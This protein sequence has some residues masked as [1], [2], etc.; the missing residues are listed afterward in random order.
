[1][2]C[3]EYNNKPEI[4]NTFKRIH[5]LSMCMKR[6]HIVI[7]GSD[8]N[9]PLYDLDERILYKFY[10]SQSRTRRICHRFSKATNRV[11]PLQ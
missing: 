7:T 11:Y 10:S 9:K 8:S 4:A 6:V 3:F 2:A 1:M 5:K